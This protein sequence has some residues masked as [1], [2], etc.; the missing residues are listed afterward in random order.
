ME[1]TRGSGPFLTVMARV[2]VP[3]VMKEERKM[4]VRGLSPLE[5]LF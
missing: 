4:D 5:F 1:L 2:E 3:S